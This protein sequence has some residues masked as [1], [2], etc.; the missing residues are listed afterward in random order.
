MAKRKNGKLDQAK[1]PAG[2]TSVNVTGDFGAWHD[3]HKQKVLQGKVLEMHKIDSEDDNGKKITKRV[4][5][6]KT[7]KG[8]VSS[9]SESFALKGLFD[10]K[11]LVGKTVYIQ[12]LGQKSFRNKKGKARKVNQFTAAVK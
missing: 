3:F 5:S 1:L 9:V 2:F 6:V 10:M 12:Y 11:G 7:D 4:I 8:V